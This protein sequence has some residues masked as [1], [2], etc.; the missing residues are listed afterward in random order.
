[1]TLPPLAGGGRRGVHR[2][3]VIAIGSN[4][5]AMCIRLVAA[6]AALAVA[7]CG[8]Q[9]LYGRAGDVAPARALALVAISPI[10][11][12]DLGPALRDA[13]AENLAPK[14]SNVQ[15]RYQLAI[16][17]IT[18]RA[19]Q[20]T[21]KDSLIRRYDL[22]VSA[23]YALSD[24]ATG[25]ALD[26]GT[27]KSVTSYNIIEAEPFASLAAEKSAGEKAAREIGREIVNRLALYFRR[28]AQS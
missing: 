11:D 9:P 27:V 15:P 20:I 6:G 8:F 1:M 19:P 26:A 5:R 2:T 28:Q 18:S 25:A 24:P 21:E 12:S 13:L 23:D 7:G 16:Q 22:I 3:D 10:E 17:L 4:R 14:G